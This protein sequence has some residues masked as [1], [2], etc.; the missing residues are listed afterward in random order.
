MTKRRENTP[1]QNGELFINVHQT[2]VPCL[3]TYGK[4]TIHKL[5]VSHHDLKYCSTPLYSASLV[6]RCQLNSSLT[7]LDRL[8]EF[9]FIDS[10]VWLSRL[11]VRSWYPLISSYGSCNR[12]MLPIINLSNQDRTVQDRTVPDRTAL[13]CNF[14]VYGNFL[15]LEELSVECLACHNHVTVMSQSYHNHVTVM[16]QSCH[17]HLTSSLF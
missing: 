1:W 17:S 15:L 10:Y 11:D 3:T 6:P 8:T 12:S 13:Y 16:S 2:I 7:R 5:S 9:F 4:D 14:W